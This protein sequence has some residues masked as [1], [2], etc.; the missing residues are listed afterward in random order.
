[1]SICIALKLCVVF[2]FLMLSVKHGK[3]CSM[4][5]PFQV[6]MKS[7]KQHLWRIRSLT[8]KNIFR[9]QNLPNHEFFKNW[10]CVLLCLWIHTISLIFSILEKLKK[11][12][13]KWM[14][15]QV[16]FSERLIGKN[17]I[18]LLF[19]ELLSLVIHSASK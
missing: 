18:H 2:F 11:W 3:Y 13:D 9:N 4:Y 7:Y 1:M 14:D 19:F 5:H 12:M 10:E 16:L 8:K 17:V 15:G 6:A